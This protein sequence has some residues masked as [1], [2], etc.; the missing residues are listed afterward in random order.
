MLF[1][2]CNPGQDKDALNVSPDE[3]ARYIGA[4]DNRY[5]QISDF[6]MGIVDWILGFFGLQHDQTL[7]ITVYALV[8]FGI[9][10]IVGLVAKWIILGIVR[11]VSA[12]V[13]LS[14]Y[15][16]LT[17]NRF[18]TKICRIIPALV[19]LV[20]IQFT[21]TGNDRLASIL[22]K[23][24]LIYVV[25]VAGVAL[26]ALIMAIWQHVDARENKRKLPLR[27]LSQ[28]AKGIVWIIAAII[29]VCIIID[30]SPAS[31][32]AGLGAFAAVLMLV[33][34]DSILGLVAGV[35][36]SENDSLHEGDWIKVDGTDANGTVVE[37]NLTS[38][39]VLNWD[40]T[41]TSLP[42]YSLISGSFTNYRSMQESNTRRICRS[43]YIDADSVLPATPEMLQ[44]F[45]SIPFM[46]AYISRKLAQRAQGKVA[47]VDNPEGLV[48]GT[49]DTNL[50]LFRAYMKMWLDN[51]KFVDSNSTCFV[52]TLQQ[53][54]GGI[55]FQIYCFTSTSA[56]LPYE[57][58]QDTIFE[59]L[60]AMLS[61]FRLY[62]FEQP[63]G[64]DTVIDG[65]LSPGGKVERVFGMPYPFFNRDASSPVG[66]E[67]WPVEPK[68]Q[69]QSS[70]PS[71][72]AAGSGS[73]Q[74]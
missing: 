73:K 1:L 41:T 35:Q 17:S 65:F 15:S 51:N 45:R 8:V 67:N 74:Q 10:I 2:L 6:V 25:I 19:F 33:F 63:S 29:I 23:V 42:P 5:S 59:H 69:S 43:Y 48:D 66:P 71:Q 53:T 62:C 14:F 38:V 36:L 47:D 12:R 44:N 64:R 60:A 57:A 28:L 34:K 31:L 37:V 22:T 27:G 3:M 20:L 7:V 21:L 52:S 49:I 30:K 39:K 56:W 54:G 13:N 11:Q 4:S 68:L 70:A 18:F 46:D 50:G 55:P 24:T 26:S 40:K 9:S 72:P 61:R 58:M 32:L 16:A